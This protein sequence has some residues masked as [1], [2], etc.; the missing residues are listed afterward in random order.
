MSINFLA[1]RLQG[2]LQSWGIN[3][4]YNTRNTH[5][6]PTKS[7]IEGMI[8][9]AFGYKRGSKEEASLL[10]SLMKCPLQTIRIPRK[11]RRFKN[12]CLEFRRMSDFHTI[13]GT[14]TATGETKN[15]HLTTRY[16]LNDAYFG[17]ILEGPSE[18]M[19]KISQS[20]QD[21]VWGIWLGRKNCIATAPI[22][23]GLFDR[24]QAALENITQGVQ[25]R[26]FIQKEVKNFVA[27]TDTIA[28]QA[29]SF[30]SKARKFIPRRIKNELFEIL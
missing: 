9:A 8:C 10:Q 30:E 23:A 3:S 26:Y 27:G 12:Q 16:Y 20:L 22:F 29:L 13:Q 14:K 19:N 28:D 17:A 15:T 5:N 18:L 6:M 1:L 4:Q 2:P 7:A 24:E 25:V 21:P 11:D